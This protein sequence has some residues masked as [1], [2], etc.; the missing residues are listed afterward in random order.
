MSWSDNKELSSGA[1]IIG[2]NSLKKNILN[3]YEKKKNTITMSPWT[4]EGDRDIL[5]ILAQCNR[6]KPTFACTSSLGFS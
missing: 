5:D 2:W 3:D 4:R 6:P 1:D